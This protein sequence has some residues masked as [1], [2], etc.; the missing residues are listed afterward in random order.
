M[1][2]NL[3]AVHVEEKLLQRA[4]I[5]HSCTTRKGAIENLNR[6][7]MQQSKSKVSGHIMSC[8]PGEI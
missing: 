7:D 4:R 8:K 6:R 1:T 5:I 2:G 3:L